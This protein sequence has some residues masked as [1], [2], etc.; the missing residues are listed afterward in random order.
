MS[1]FTHSS[2]LILTLSAGILL[3]EGLGAGVDA[4]LSPFADIVGYYQLAVL[5]D[6]VSLMA[7]VWR[8]EV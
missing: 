1:I 6:G 3:A 5:V 7:S 2:G 8:R 4:G